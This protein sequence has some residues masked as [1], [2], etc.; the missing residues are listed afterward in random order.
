MWVDRLGW[1]L[2]GMFLAYLFQE[3]QEETTGLVVLHRFEPESQGD[4]LAT[5]S[6]GE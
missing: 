4:A 5:E 1:I 3:W 6:K 2:I